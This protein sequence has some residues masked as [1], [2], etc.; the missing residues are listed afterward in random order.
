MNA[1]DRLY[2]R[3]LLSGRDIARSDPLARQ[4]VNF[5]YLVGDRETGEAV[6]IDAAY[7]VRSILDVAAADGMTITG[8]LVTHYHQ[9]HVGGDMMGYRISGLRELLALNPVPVHVQGDEAAGVQR[10]TGAGET[11][12]V[13]HRSGDVV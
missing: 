4:M 3:Q 13:R 12:L 9:D 6:A 1:P 10:V 2:F 8:A 7:D 5:V 11:D